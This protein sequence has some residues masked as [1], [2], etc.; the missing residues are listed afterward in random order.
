[1]NYQ[2][3]E[4]RMLGC[5]VAAVQ[6]MEKEGDKSQDNIVPP[7]NNWFTSNAYQADE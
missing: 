6:A 7:P 1:M 4:V 3:P 5:A 2:K